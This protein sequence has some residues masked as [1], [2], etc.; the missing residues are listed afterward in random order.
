MEPKV[1][2]VIPNQISSAS[3]QNIESIDIMIG[4]DKINHQ[5]E[6]MASPDF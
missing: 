6:E 3:E 5:V 4:G 1:K 2:Q